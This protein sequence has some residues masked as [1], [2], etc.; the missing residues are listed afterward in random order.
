MKQSVRL[1]MEKKANQQAKDKCAA[2]IAEME[3]LCAAYERAKQDS[4][5][6][7]DEKAWS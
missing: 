4:D 3:A 1:E 6:N 2:N 5:E 7:E